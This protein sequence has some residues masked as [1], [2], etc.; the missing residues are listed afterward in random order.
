MITVTVNSDRID[1]RGHARAGPYG[2][3]IVCAAVSALV[4]TLEQAICELTNDVIDCE[5]GSGH[6]NLI[7]KHL[8]SAAWLLVDAFLL[9]VSR[10]AES[11][12]ENVRI[13]REDTPKP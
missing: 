13:V 12:P 4:Q 7:T 6:F 5:I 1:I 2:Q 11:Y 8:S 9:G 10:I 3:D